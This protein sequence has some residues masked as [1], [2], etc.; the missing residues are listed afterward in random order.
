[1]CNFVKFYHKSVSTYKG[2]EEVNVVY[3]KN[4]STGGILLDH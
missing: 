3:N 1:M 4:R 2:K